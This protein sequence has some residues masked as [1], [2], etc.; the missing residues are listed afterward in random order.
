MTS[1][2]LPGLWQAAD[3]LWAQATFPWDD[4]GSSLISHS[5]CVPM[6]CF[7]THYL[8]ISSHPGLSEHVQQ[9]RKA[10]FTETADTNLAYRLCILHPSLDTQEC[11]HTGS[12]SCSC[13]WITTFSSLR[14]FLHTISFQEKIK[15][16]FLPSTSELKKHHIVFQLMKQ[17][18]GKPN[19]HK[20]L[21]ATHIYK[22]FS[23][24]W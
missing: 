11:G 22:F 19:R 2:H 16:V 21:P 7:N 20:I 3:L 24:R 13:T 10:E 4:T 12:N 8:C 9:S 1:Q 17:L 14:G 15:T 5:A 6:L 18:H 23:S